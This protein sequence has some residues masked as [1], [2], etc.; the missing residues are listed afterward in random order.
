[1]QKPRII[2]M[3]RFFFE[4]KTL[5]VFPTTIGTRI[6]G[7]FSCLKPYIKKKIVY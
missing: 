4:K 2:G 3:G 5:S 6:K 1:M 7:L